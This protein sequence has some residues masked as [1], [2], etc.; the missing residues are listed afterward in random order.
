[1]PA[2]E[3]AL[4]V[5]EHAVVLIAPRFLRRVEPS[6]VGIEQVVL[7]RYPGDHTARLVIERAVHATLDVNGTLVGEER[8]RAAQ[9]DAGDGS[10]RIPR[11][12]LPT[13]RGP[14]EPSPWPEDARRL[15]ALTPAQTD[16]I[17]HPRRATFNR[18]ARAVVRVVIE[19]PGPVETRNWIRCSSGPPGDGILT[20]PRKRQAVG[21]RPSADGRAS[22][23]VLLPPIGTVLRGP[24]TRPIAIAAVAATQPVGEFPVRPLA[25]IPYVNSPGTKV[26]A[27]ERRLGPDQ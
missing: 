18:D 21:L 25:R 12:K 7:E 22:G 27:T 6:A 19:S 11:G 26:A 16:P 5:A 14:R 2:P 17:A 10:T 3:G 1:M 23:R 9:S 24:R 13:I 4:R 15:N 20:L 8:L